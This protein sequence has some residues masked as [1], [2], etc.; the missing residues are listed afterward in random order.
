MP[1]DRFLVGITITLICA[2]IAIITIP[3]SHTCPPVS[4]DT[5]IIP[6]EHV[7][8]DTMIPS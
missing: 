7:S 2:T 6:V 3:L 5:I 4:D 1:Y 8:H